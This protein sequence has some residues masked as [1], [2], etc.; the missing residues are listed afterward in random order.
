M[1]ITMQ[2]GGNRVIQTMQHETLISRCNMK[3]WLAEVTTLIK[4]LND[5]SENLHWQDD[6]VHMSYTNK[7][8]GSWYRPRSRGHMLSLVG[9]RGQVLRVTGLGWARIH[10]L[11]LVLHCSTQSWYLLSLR[12][13]WRRTV[14]CLPT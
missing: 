4:L 10:Y 13:V 9:D 6:V 5:L 3:R 8:P 7:I 2:Q 1:Q 12:C 14:S 11:A